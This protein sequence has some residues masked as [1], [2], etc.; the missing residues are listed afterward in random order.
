MAN[1]LLADKEEPNQ[2]PYALQKTARVTQEKQ[3]Y[4]FSIWNTV[5]IAKHLMH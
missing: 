1:T 4:K 3:A 2:K 5:T